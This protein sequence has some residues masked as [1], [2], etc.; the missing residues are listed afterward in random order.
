MPIG[1]ESARGDDEAIV[2]IATG[3]EFFDEKP[4]HNRLA[5]ARIVGEEIAQWNARKHFLIDGSN[6]MRQWDD[7][8]RMHGI[9]WIE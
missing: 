1:D 9:E 5:R 3:A 8:G 7:I 6:L 4:G 2:E